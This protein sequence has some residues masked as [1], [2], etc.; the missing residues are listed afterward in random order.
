MA[1]AINAISTAT[2]LI[3][4]PTM[5]P[6]WLLPSPAVGAVVAREGVGGVVLEVVEEDDVVVVVDVVVVELE[7]ELE[8]LFDEV[9]LELVVVVVVA[10]LVVLKL[11]DDEPELEA[12][13]V[14]IVSIVVGAVSVVGDAVSA[15]EKLLSCTDDRPD[16]LVATVAAKV[17]AEPHPYWKKPP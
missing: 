13:V 5:A 14:V 8:L 4:P 2:P 1:S 10:V 9:E 12:E 11:L 6:M 3:V 17:D 15:A 7:L 16:A